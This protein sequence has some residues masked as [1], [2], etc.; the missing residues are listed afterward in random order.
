MLVRPLRFA[1]ALL[2]SAIPLFA[3]SPTVPG[4]LFGYRDFAKQAEIDREFLK[5]PDATL[6]GEE[7]KR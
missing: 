6:A 4:S 5:V 3:Q 2:A 7:L 1:T